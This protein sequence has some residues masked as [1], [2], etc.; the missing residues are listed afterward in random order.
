MNLLDH[1]HAIEATSQKMLMSAQGGCWADVVECEAIC[2]HIISKLRVHSEVESLTLSLLHGHH[3]F[4]NA[5][6]WIFQL[7][8]ALKSLCL[9]LRG[10]H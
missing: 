9:I 6:I 1:Y 7:N 8:F 5:D 10:A 2:L 3:G 4:F